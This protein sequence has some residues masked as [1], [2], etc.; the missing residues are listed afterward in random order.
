MA[1]LV[2]YLNAQP[3][4]TRFP[5][6]VATGRAVH[7][8]RE[9]ARIN[10]PAGARRAS[11]VKLAHLTVFGCLKARLPR[12]MPPPSDVDTRPCSCAPTRRSKSLS[13]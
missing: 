7:V 4:S 11:T 12:P 1:K 13:G 3:I 2:A 8:M 10:L 6:R 9:P 5:I